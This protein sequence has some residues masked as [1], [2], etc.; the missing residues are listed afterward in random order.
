MRWQISDTHPSDQMGRD[1]FRINHG[2]MRRHV[3]MQVL[4]VDAPEGAQISTERRACP[5]TGIA[6]NLASAIPIVIPCP[7]VGAVAH[8]GMAAV[9]ALPCIHV[10]DRAAG[11]NVLRHRVVAGPFGPVVEAPEAPLACVPR[12]QTDNGGTIVGVGAVPFPLIGAPVGRISGL[13][14]ERAPF[15]PR[16]CIARPPEKRCRSSHQSARYRSDWLGCVVAGYA[17]FLEG[18]THQQRVV[19]IAAPATV[20]RE[21]AL[22]TEQPPHRAATVRTFQA[23]WVQV[24]LQ[25]KR[26][27]ALVQ[28]FGD[29][30]VD[31][32]AILPYAA[33]WLRMSHKY[34]PSASF[35]NSPNFRPSPDNVPQVGG[36]G[37][38]NN[39]MAIYARNAPDGNNLWTAHRTG[40][41]PYGPYQFER[42]N[43]IYGAVAWYRY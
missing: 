28:Q 26:A 9:I 31:H 7:F 13:R 34:L 14:M 30:E 16:C 39:H 43:K 23:V 6:V 38:W 18:R 27:D 4:L 37:R 2:F 20:S 17:A 11:R 10:Q 12:P 5:F 32:A 42:Y 21:M 22:M 36:V 40:G 41:A 29:W 24:P 1:A 35:P 33:R 15:P 3:Q 19:A 25:P 8:G